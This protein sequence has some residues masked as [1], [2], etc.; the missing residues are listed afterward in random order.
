VCSVSRVACR[1]SRVLDNCT[2]SVSG[3][4]SLTSCPS[5]IRSESSKASKKPAMRKS[6]SREKVFD[7]SA[8]SR[9][10]PGPG[11]EIEGDPDSGVVESEKVTV[12][13][14][15]SARS[16]T[17]YTQLPSRLLLGLCMHRARSDW[18]SSD[19]PWRELPILGVRAY[20]PSASRSHITRRSR[21]RT[22]AAPSAALRPSG[23]TRSSRGCRECVRGVAR[24]IATGSGLGE[25]TFWAQLSSSVRGR[26]TRVS[27]CG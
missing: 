11:D 22:T 23:W 21:R 5:S 26:S 17:H 20:T 13:F 8:L 12:V 6:A 16:T 18:F 3:G 2:V 7:L 15:V 9:A 27:S 19:S 24:P 25:L 10:I 14:L 4:L 1:V